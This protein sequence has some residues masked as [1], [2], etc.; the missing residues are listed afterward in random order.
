MGADEIIE[1]LRKKFERISGVL[2]ERGRRVWAAAEAEALGY[3]GQSIVARATGLARTTIYR[4][5]VRHA[6]DS[7]TPQRGRIRNGGDGRN[8]LTA[9]EPALLSALEAL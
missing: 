3:G 8:K 4:E 9:R 6:T 1:T 5:G 7:P 2:D